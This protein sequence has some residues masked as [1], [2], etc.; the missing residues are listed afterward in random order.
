MGE[1]RVFYA[2]GAP[3][4][5]GAISPA[6]SPSYLTQD[7]RALA[8]FGQAITQQGAAFL[9]HIQRVDVFNQTTEIEGATT[10]SYSN[11]LN[12]L[13]TDPDPSSYLS[14]YG[15]WSKAELKNINA[16]K[17]PEARRRATGWYNKQSASWYNQVQSN[18]TDRVIRDSKAAFTLGI[19]R[20][21]R[22]RD[23]D[24][25]A[26]ATTKAFQSGATGENE[27]AVVLERGLEAIAKGRKDDFLEGALNQA[28]LNPEEAISIVNREFDDRRKGESV[29]EGIGLLT[30]TDLETI[31]D[32]ANS[33]GE[34][35][36]SDSL[37]AANAAVTA[38]YQQ[39]IKGSV[40][41][42]QHA[43]LILSDPTISDEDKISAVN[44]IKSFF[45]TWN[46]ATKKDGEDIVT[47]DSTRIKTLRVIQAV[48]TGKMTV[49][50]GLDVYTIISKVEGINGTDGKGFINDI[51][52]AGETAQK[53]E[54][55]RQNEI[56]GAREKQLRDAIEKQQNILDPSMATEIL[57]D[58]ANI[59]V[60]ELNNIFR[61]DEF[62]DDD[63]KIQTD[64]LIQKYTL[65]ELQQ[66]NAVN[67]RSLRL[68][69]T[70][71]EQQESLTKIMATL[72][73]QGKTVEAQAIMDEAIELGIFTKDGETIK[74]GTG[75]KRNVGVEA[76]K[77]ILDSITK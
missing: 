3:P 45:S 15:E 66:A 19:D 47:S 69:E 6:P 1:V 53:A 52:S 70:L 32:Y 26:R 58:F 72:K 65:S 41:I 77:R 36:K 31:K 57:Q 48:K 76:I 10:E 30:N 35:V 44:K 38:S 62:T 16:M 56:L 11:F 8:G 39:I 74:K 14:K 4:S 71:K 12:N 21:I 63:V 73:T 46:S 24:A 42:Q 61:E 5:R 22:D 25:L 33:V 54:A 7:R 18:A 20:A 13:A 64:R 27:A 29:D 59:A 17:N 51:F 75:K 60:I 49:D 37:N 68:A 55:V 2:Q 67:A 9:D 50:E 34:K 40:D 28:A 23:P 43:A